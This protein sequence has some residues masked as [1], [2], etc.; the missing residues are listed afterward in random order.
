MRA[1][2]ATLFLLFVAA[3]AVLA[4]LSVPARAQC[5]ILNIPPPN[6]RVGVVEPK[7]VYHHDL[8]LFG[9]QK[10]GNS[11]ERPPPGSIRLG[12]TFNADYV[13]WSFSTYPFNLPDG[14]VCIWLADVDAELGDPV[15]NV[16]VAEEYAPG[17]CEYN[18]VLNHENTH[19]RFMLG[20]LHKWAPSIQA[21]LS[22]AA[23]HKFPVVFPAKPTN[24][25]LSQYLGGNMDDIFALM[26]D[27]MTRLNASIDTPENYRRENAKCHNWSRHGL[28]LDQPPSSPASP[29]N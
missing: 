10:L 24:Q 9:L 11:A 14:R 6:I 12:V 16:Y 29:Q 5:P 18:V 7:I 15:M 22:E 13:K 1:R 21:A 3:L 4:G 28:H 23:K 17:S 20:S 8:D 25:Q 27:E 19:V 26:N 2:A